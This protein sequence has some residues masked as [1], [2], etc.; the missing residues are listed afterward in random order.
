MPAY[1]RLE[2]I[3]FFIFNFF[4]LLLGFFQVHQPQISPLF[5]IVLFFPSSPHAHLIPTRGAMSIRLVT[6]CPITHFYVCTIVGV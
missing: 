4:I 6:F 5:F 2:N 1:T 3:H